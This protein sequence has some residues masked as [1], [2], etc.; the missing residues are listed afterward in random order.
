MFLNTH[1]AVIA[2]ES[3]MNTQLVKIVVLFAFTGREDKEKEEYSLWDFPRGS[4]LLFGWCGPQNTGSK[5][6]QT[7]LW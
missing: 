2:P 5:V 7:L 6:S 4:Q 1:W 3:K